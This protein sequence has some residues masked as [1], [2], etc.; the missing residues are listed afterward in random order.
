MSATWG[1]AWVR[2]YCHPSQSWLAL[3]YSA[4]GLGTDILRVSAA[5]RGRIEC[6]ARDPFAVVAL[7]C[8]IDPVDRRRAKKDF[9]ALLADGFIVLEGTVLVVRN[10]ERAQETKSE[11]AARKAAQREREREKEQGAGGSSSKTSAE[12]RNDAGTTPERHASDIGATSERHG[13][14]AGTDPTSRKDTNAS[15]TVTPPLKTLRKTLTE[16]LTE[17]ELGTKKEEIV[18]TSPEAGT[19]LPV[20]PPPSAKGKRQGQLTLS[21][22]EPKAKAPKAEPLPFSVRQGLDAIATKTTRFTAPADGELSKGHAI[23]LGK[24]VRRFPRLE[25]WSLVGEYLNANGEGWRGPIGVSLIASDRFAEFVAAA[26][27]WE[28]AGKRRMDIRGSPID[29]TKGRAEGW[30]HARLGLA[31]IG[32]EEMGNG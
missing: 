3:S 22:P 7:L 24:Q 17:K 1:Y 8:A 19:A 25:E 4:R 11:A 27:A 32:V 21:T 16:T 6:G 10:F 23:A 9:E 31:D 29:P 28:K 13:N 18:P 15:V 26:R 30:E 5:T 20:E 2:L 12:H 14:D